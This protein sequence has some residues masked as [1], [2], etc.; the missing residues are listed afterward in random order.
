[1][2]ANS[3]RSYV[4]DHIEGGYTDRAIH[5]NTAEVGVQFSELAADIIEDILDGDGRFEKAIRAAAAISE[6]SSHLS[7]M[8]WTAA[9]GDRTTAKKLA[10]NLVQNGRKNS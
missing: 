10:R 5:L 6:I 3:A 9:D 4:S 8:A 1:M 2:G 7:H